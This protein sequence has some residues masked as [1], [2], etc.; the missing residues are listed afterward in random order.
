[1]NTL[2]GLLLSVSLFTLGGLNTMPEQQPNQSAFAEHT[3]SYEV[4]KMPY[5]GTA[6]TAWESIR[7]QGGYKAVSDAQKTYVAIGLGQRSTGGY[8]VVV[9]NV[10]KSANGEILIKARER[11]PKPGVMTTQA[12]TYPAVVIS[13]PKTTKSVKVVFE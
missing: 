3:I 11:G 10:M 7:K 6:K 1:M 12:L 4:V 9:T 13:I 8:S 5:P 2:F